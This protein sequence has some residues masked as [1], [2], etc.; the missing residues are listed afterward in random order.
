MKQRD[1]QDRSPCHQ[2]CSIPE[3]FI[4]RLAAALLPRLFA[5][6]IPGHTTRAPQVG[7]ELATNSIQF[8]VFANL[9]KTS[10]NVM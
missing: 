5:N 9:D 7:F 4:L 2:T 8:Y 6:R 3:C 10:L 1:S